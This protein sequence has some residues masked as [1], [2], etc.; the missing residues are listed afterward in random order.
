M[1]KAD[2]PQ[3]IRPALTPEAEENQLIALATDLAKKQLQDGTAS[4]QTINHFLKLA[5]PKE[6]LERDILEK[7]SQLIA[8]KTEAL[9]SQQRQEALYEEALKAFKTYQPSNDIDEY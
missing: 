3:K 5:S 4:S 9:Q 2:T 8:A 6:R 7:Q 1:R